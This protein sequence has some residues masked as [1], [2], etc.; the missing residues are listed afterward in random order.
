MNKSNISFIIP[1]Y[2]CADMIEESVDSIFNGNFE[3]GDEVIIVN[4]A[5]TDTTADTLEKL[6]EKY[7]HLIVL[8]H[9]INKGTAAA[10]R[11]TAIQASRNDLIFTLD[12]DN[13]LVPGSI[14]KLKKFLLDN[15]IDVA[16]FREIWF[17]KDTTNNITQKWIFNE[18]ITAQNALAGNITPCPTGNYL[19][20]KTSWTKA[21]TYFEP[22]IINQTLDSW[23]FGVRQLFTGAKILTL[24]DSYYLHRTGINS[25]WIR[26]NRKGNVSLAALVAIMPFLE[27][28]EE[29]DLDY[30]F[31]KEGRFTWFD[32]LQTK[33]IRLKNEMILEDRSQRIKLE[34]NS[35]ILYRIKALIRKLI[36]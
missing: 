32:N 36:Q 7:P 16:V 10:G 4:D 18:E 33:P 8:R 2:N 31:S 19:F 28:I 15:N 35:K 9:A 34:K 29:L 23:T 24:K 25:H 5:S 20:T 27:K 22:T 26:E 30:I 21:G 1:A 17:F 11:N 3:D 13:I 6:K 14:Q 12:S